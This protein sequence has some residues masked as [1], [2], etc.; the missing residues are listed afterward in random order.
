MDKKS[1]PLVYMD[2]FTT[3]PVNWVESS[4]QCVHFVPQLV[5]IYANFN[6]SPLA[7]YKKAFRDPLTKFYGRPPLCPFLNSIFDA[8]VLI[9]PTAPKAVCRIYIYRIQQWAV[10]VCNLPS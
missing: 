1:S 10:A 6:K 9:S 7:L 3:L 8:G 5:G 4:Y 2:V